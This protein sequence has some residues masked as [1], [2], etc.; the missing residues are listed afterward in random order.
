MKVRNQPLIQRILVFPIL[1]LLLSTTADASLSPEDA[2]KRKKIRYALNQKILTPYEI[3]F[4]T[5]VNL[6]MFDE[7]SFILRANNQNVITHR[8]PGRYYSRPY[9]TNGRL[10]VFGNAAGN[11][12]TLY[13]FDPETLTLIKTLKNRTAVESEGGIRVVEGKK[14]VWGLLS[15]SPKDGSDRAD[16]AAV[17]DTEQN[18]VQV[19]RFDDLHFTGA[20]DVYNGIL[21]TG[22]CGERIVAW[23]L[24][25]LSHAGNY[26]TRP[27]SRQA[28]S[29]FTARECI[30][31]VYRLPDRLLGE[32]ART[33]YLWDIPGKSKPAAYPKTETGSL[34]HCFQDVLIE[35]KGSSFWK[36]DIETGRTLR[37]GETDSPI[38]DLIVTNEKIFSDFD[39]PLLVLSLRHNRGLL[40]YDLTTFTEIRRIDVPGVSMAASD[41]HLFATDDRHLYKY[42]IAHKNKTEY[43]AFIS[44]I[45]PKQITVTPRF[46]DTLIRRLSAYP[47]FLTETGL[48]QRILSVFPL[49]IHHRI[50]YGVIGRRMENGSGS[51]ESVHGYRVSYE[52]VNESNHCLVVGIGFARRGWFGNRREMEETQVVRDFDS[53]KRIDFSDPG[54][55]QYRVMSPGGSASG[56]FVAGLHEPRRIAVYPVSI[57]VKEAE[58]CTDFHRALTGDD[59]EPAVLRRFLQD[60]ALRS[61]HDR[62]KARLK[63]IREQKRR[64]DW[65]PWR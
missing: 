34:T 22:A 47:F 14:A 63:K 33:Y 12:G 60:P 55:A 15:G 36:R 11:A 30:T 43:E 31:G 49:Q 42:A 62:L 54:P 61:W 40:F 45:D 56:E 37:R 9:F 35:Y 32:S 52:A 20:V 24:S 10:W 53:G 50:R 29:E 64:F 26:L 4:H 1:F 48:Q 17:W 7:I 23:D 57:D 51:E 3:P 6:E 5:Y 44:G 65:L 38:E 25:T 27:A 46:A 18:R 58:Y 16:V 41:N 8:F 13:E 2:E 19:V 21:Y 39:G 59:I 28:V